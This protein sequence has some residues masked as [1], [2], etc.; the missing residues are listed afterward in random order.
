VPECLYKRGP[1]MCVCAWVFLCVWTRENKKKRRRR[2]RRTGARINSP[3]PITPPLWGQDSII[4]I[5]IPQ[6]LTQGSSFFLS[7]TG[8]RYEGWY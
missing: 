7:S 2:R 5:I 4:I 1:C 6:L 3:S 8:R